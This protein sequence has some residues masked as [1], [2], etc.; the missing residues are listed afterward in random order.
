MPCLLFVLPG[1]TGWARIGNSPRI[2]SRGAV[3]FRVAPRSESSK[4]AL[5]DIVGAI[6]F[7]VLVWNNVSSLRTKNKRRPERAAVWTPHLDYLAK[8]Q[9]STQRDIEVHFLRVWVQDSH[10]SSFCLA[11]H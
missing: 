3:V 10:F 9:C 6:V 5:V 1:R 11:S 4:K 8:I 2:E 7:R